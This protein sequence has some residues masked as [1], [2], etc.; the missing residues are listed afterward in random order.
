MKKSGKENT[1][2]EDDGEG[3]IKVKNGVIEVNHDNYQQIVDENP[4]LLLSAT[5]PWCGHC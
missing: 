2:K 4:Y 3:G 5:A 1:K